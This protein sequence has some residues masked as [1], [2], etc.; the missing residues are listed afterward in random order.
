MHT[1]FIMGKFLRVNFPHLLAADFG[2][3][4]A[5]GGLSTDWGYF[6]LT[7]TYIFITASLL[8]LVPFFAA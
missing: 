7:G 3:N 5:M 8:L 1:K 2:S 6:F 4:T